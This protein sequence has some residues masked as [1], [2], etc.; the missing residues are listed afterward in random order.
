M[1]DFLIIATTA[2]EIDLHIKTNRVLRSGASDCSVGSYETHPIVSTLIKLVR[3]AFGSPDGISQLASKIYKHLFLAFVFSDDWVASADVSN[4]VYFAA[5]VTSFVSVGQ[6]SL[7]WWILS[8]PQPPYGL[9]GMYFCLRMNSFSRMESAF[10]CEIVG[11]KTSRLSFILG[12]F[13]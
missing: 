9:V 3:F 10:C 4:V 8:S 5:A 12:V 7:C 13:G 11:S 1:D 6:S 2:F